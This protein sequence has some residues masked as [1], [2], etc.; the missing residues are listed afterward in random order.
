[1]DEETEQAIA[2]GLRQGRA[3][4]WRAFHDA[5]AEPLWRRIARLMGGQT[6][7]VADVVQETF[8]AAAR[9]ARQYDSARGSLWWWL[10][11]IARHHIAI[12]YRRKGRDDR[13]G[14]T[15]SV[16]AGDHWESWLRGREMEPSEA[17]MACELAGLVRSALLTLPADYDALLTA[18]Y[19]EGMPVEEMARSQ[20]AGIA[21]VRSKLARARRAFRAAFARLA[22]RAFDDSARPSHES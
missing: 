21:A 20:R 4:A 6:A 16:D 22:P 17:V 19:L 14:A 9:S 13:C 5:F 1:M 18:R 11:G 8:L 10:C 15:T 3:D 12:H 2:D 7:D